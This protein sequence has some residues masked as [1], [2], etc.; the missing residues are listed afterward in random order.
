L[1]LPYHMMAVVEFVVPRRSAATTMCS[2]LRNKRTPVI[3]RCSCRAMIEFLPHARV[4]TWS[5]VGR[6]GQPAARLFAHPRCPRRW[7]RSRQACVQGSEG[8][9]GPA[10]LPTDPPQSGSTWN[11]AAVKPSSF[12]T[13]APTWPGR[14][15]GRNSS[16]YFTPGR[17]CQRDS[18]PNT[19]ATPGWPAR[20]ARRPSRW[21]RRSPSRPAASRG[22]VPRTTPTL[23]SALLNNPA[24]SSGS[25]TGFIRPTAARTTPRSG[26]RPQEGPGRVA[27]FSFFEVVQRGLRPRSER[28][29]TRRGV[30]PGHHRAAVQ[31]IAEALAWGETAP[32]TNTGLRPRGE[33]R[34]RAGHAGWRAGWIFRL[35]VV[36]THYSVRWSP[37]CRTAVQ[38]LSAV[39]ARRTLRLR[40]RDY[41]NPRPVKHVWSF[42]RDM[43][44]ELSLPVSR[45]SRV[46]EPCLLVNGAGG[47][48]RAVGRRLAGWARRPRGRAGRAAGVAV[49]A[50]G[51]V[52]G[53]PTRLGREGSAGR[54]GPARGARGRPAPASRQRGPAP[55]S[56]TRT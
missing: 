34:P 49:P 24:Q 2:S 45:W 6:P 37:R 46:A 28:Q 15:R 23:T 29:I 38:E 31:R 52:G 35:R 48:I 1:K 5:V 17:T 40:V 44:P 4:S 56:A 55:A 14:E 39:R 42:P 43:S 51:W 12:S 8:R 50:P 47:L 9:G 36:N 18:N 19:R 30:R 32:S 33:R 21:P 53:R 11:S 13:T 27:F 10:A 3:S 22:R 26:P 7:C 20:R 41:T 25:L 54:R 16:G